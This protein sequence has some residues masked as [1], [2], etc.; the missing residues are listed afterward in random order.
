MQH[1]SYV[2]KLYH[3]YQQADIFSGLGLR[4]SL[5]EQDVIQTAQ[6]CCMSK[7]GY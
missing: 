3:A 4:L 5:S 1:P 7:E 2:Y 6:M